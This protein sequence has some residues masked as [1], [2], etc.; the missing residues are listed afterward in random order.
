MLSIEPDPLRVTAVLGA[1]GVGGAESWL[2]GLTDHLDHV[3]ID[4]VALAPGPA[5]DLFAARGHR[6][7]VLDTGASAAA[8]AAAAP[9][10]ARLLGSS[11][12]DV[13]LA[14]GVKAAAVAVPA[15]ILAGTRTVW[16]KHD[17]VWDAEIGTRLARM[18]DSVVATSTEL[19]DA[20]ASRAGIVIPP[21]WPSTPAASRTEAVAFWQA[22]G[23]EFTGPTLV[24]VGRL[25]GYKG[26]DDA[27]RAVARCPGWQL[28]VVGEDDR[29]APGHGDELRKLVAEIGCGDRVAFVGSVPDA[30]RWLRPFTATAVLTKA[31]PE[32][33]YDREGFS[34]TA[35]ESVAAGVPVIATSPTPALG[36]IGEAGV[37]VTPA[38]P[39][40]IAA[41]LDRWA[42]EPPVIDHVTARLAADH[43]DRP[44]AS[45]MLASHLAAVAR[46]AGAEVGDGPPL[47]VVTTVLNEGAAIRDLVQG[48]V[49]QLRP[50]DELVVVDGGSTDATI[51]SLR[52]AASANPRIRVIVAEGANISRGRNIGIAAA[53][54]DHVAITDAGCT[55]RPGWLD[56][57]RRGFAGEPA[58]DLV[59][60]VYR[61]STET[62]LDEA[63]ALSCYPDPDEARHPTLVARAAAP[64]FGKTFLASMPTGRSAAFTRTAWERAGRFREDL[65][66][67]EDVTFGRAI[68][69]TGG[70]AVLT[71]DA[72]VTWQQRPSAR[73]TWRMFH[74]YGRDGAHS[75]D[76]LLIG[77][78]LARAA[79]YAL[80]PALVLGGGRV[81]RRI[82]ATGAVLY[83]LPSTARGLRNDASAAAIALA[84]VT[85]ALKDLAKATGCLRGLADRV[86]M[87]APVSSGQQ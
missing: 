41:V 11:R 32:H 61:V 83:C 18:A 80:A 27:I 26:V 74:R 3:E 4:V 75:G 77:R 79:V 19:L 51:T 62:A 35:L 40:E 86:R 48:L 73:A 10:L 50:H 78:D 5:A 45:R 70:R 37:A 84:P 1:P 29:S 34:I 22:R 63:S 24:T 55:P 59:T 60:G 36:V 87:R 31:H 52:A 64:V 8:V 33:R 38:S 81:G 20:V 12:P 14:N 2:Y 43:P 13:V 65:P 53:A 67:A 82:T 85:L 68:V 76:R 15:G 57:L 9:R 54:H 49:E 16:A 71:A 56:A 44:K 25:I 72:A 7:H 39:G 66:T 30:G 58:P 21:P 17:F 28:V 47:S 42:A 23:V 6:V 69:A 46:R